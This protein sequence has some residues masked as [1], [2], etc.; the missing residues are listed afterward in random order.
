MSARTALVLTACTAALLLGSPARAQQPDP[1]LD[2]IFADWQNRRERIKT[3]RYHASG[4]RVW[5]KGSFGDPLTERPLG[6]DSPPTDISCPMSVTM[7][8]D[9]TTNRHR[10]VL[11]EVTYSQDQRQFLPRS[12]T[13]IVFDSKELTA[14]TSWPDGK[15]AN[16][17]NPD[18]TIASGN[19]RSCGF[20]VEYWPLFLGHGIIALMTEHHI[21][22]GRL[23][24][25]N[26]KEIYHV[27]G[28]GVYAGR[29]C[30][31]LRT[32][33]VE[34]SSV[35]YDELWVD[36]ARESA[37]VRQ[38]YYDEDKP[39]MDIQVDYQQTAKGWL[40]RGWTEIY[41]RKNGQTVWVLR[42]HVD[43]VEIDPPVKDADF[44]VDVKPGM[45]VQRLNYPGSPDQ[46]VG[47]APD[48]ERLY[49]VGPG[50]EWNEIV[51]GVEQ[52]AQW[53]SYL[54]AGLIVLA[55]GFGAAA[56]LWWR[57]KRRRAA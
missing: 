51:H 4:E 35:G 50:G 42:M 5:P 40:P 16:D 48:S 57:S 20:T 24:K 10:L 22:P 31:V 34:Y 18:V 32:E 33:A 21:L 46:I 37:V 45:L 44:R 7:L 6:P 3:I 26:E 39:V 56:L 43:D 19:M 13:T 52:K 11:D 47:V 1:R 23:T 17:T 36:P 15:P 8:L 49:R 29:P 55:A 38:L 53:P 27:Q 28:E 54:W 12:V 14:Q 25:P 30:V 41:P 9:F 2:K